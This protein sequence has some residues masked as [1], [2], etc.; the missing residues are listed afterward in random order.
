MDHFLKLTACTL[1]LLPLSTFAQSEAR[2]LRYPAISPDGKTIAFSYQGDLWRV[3][4]TGGTATLLTTSDAYEYAPVWSHDGKWLAFA[5][6]RHGDPDV[7][8]MPAAGGPATRLTENSAG[9]MPSDFTPD[10]KAVLFAS[11]RVGDVEDRQFPSGAFPQLYS[12]PVTGGEAL[13]VL[14]TT[15]MNA[16]FDPSGTHIAYTD[17]KG[18]EN[19]YR[20]HHTSSVTRDIWSY[21]LATKRYSRLSSFIG[22]DRDPV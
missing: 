20:K 13:R 3:E 4:A 17:N 15:A 19:L 18:Y 22:E 14:T 16:H 8:I 1:A 7:F 6:D 11:G 9:D 10:D 5:S 12:V 21:D 2:W